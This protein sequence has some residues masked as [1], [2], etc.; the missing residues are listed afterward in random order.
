FS[1][2][3]RQV[4]VGMDIGTSKVSR[5][6]MRRVPHHGL[7][8]RPPDRSVSLSDYQ[9]LAIERLREINARGRLPLLIGGTGSYILSV[10]QNWKVGEDLLESE[11]NFRARGRGAP[12]FR[13]AFIRPSISREALMPRIDRAVE[14]MFEAGLVD[15]VIGLA[16]RYRLWE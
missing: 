7:D 15:E 10:V 12:L 9:A 13:A 4:Y 6:V 5:E 1:A 16:E 2:D 11:A 14:R 8:L 3:S